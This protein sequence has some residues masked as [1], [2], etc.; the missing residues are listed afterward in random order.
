MPVKIAIDVMGGE[1]APHAPVRAAILYARERP[2]IQIVLIG[3]EAKIYSNVENS[4]PTNVNICHTVDVITDNDEP[5]RAVRRKTQASLVLAA[6]M[7]RDGVADAMISAGNTGALVASGLLVVG[8]MAEISRPAL[9][10]VLPSFE[11]KGVL[12]LDAGATMDATAQNLVQYAHMGAIY[13]KDVLGIES[14]RIGLINVGSESGKGTALYKEAHELLKQTDINFVGNI[15]A[16]F[17]MSGV[18]DVAICDG[19]VG[20]VIL[21]TAEGLGMGIFSALRD[22]LTEKWTTK[23]AALILKSSFRTFR[24]RFDYAEYGGAPFLGVNGG[25]F[26]AH[27]S[28][29]ERAW[30]TAIQQAVKFVEGR[31]LERLSR[32]LHE[33]TAQD[34][35]HDVLQPEGGTGK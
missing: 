17:L 16:R 14:P 3:D 12:L 26:K 15:E 31:T 18:C 33:L 30:F 22:T 25:V 28:S 23:L 20:N 29:K 6:G 8:R 9:A 21:K 35:T 24:N 19:F 32:R 7:V 4:L 27:G 2:D 34:E 13:S 5:V 1:H 11:R 10:P